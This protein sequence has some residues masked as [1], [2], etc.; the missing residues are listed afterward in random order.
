MKKFISGLLGIL[1]VVLVVV[2]VFICT[3]VFNQPS[4]SGDS[5]ELISGT[6]TDKDANITFEFSDEGD[7][8]IT[9]TDNKSVIAKGWFKIQEDGGSGKIQLLV[10]PS[11]RD[12][13]VDI[14]LRM[15]FFS[16]ISYKNNR[17]RNFYFRIYF[18]TIFDG[19]FPFL[20]DL[21]CGF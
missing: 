19:R 11:D 1:F 17:K 6:W 13:T 18:F 5:R 12:T 3:Y 2:G 8:T 9:H 20:I 4:R 16:T 21:F 15:K 10:N 7:F 14:G